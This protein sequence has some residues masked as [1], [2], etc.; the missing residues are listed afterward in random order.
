M[1]APAAL[2]LDAHLK[3]SLAAI[4]S[5]G[6][7]GIPVHV[8]SHRSNAMGFYSRCVASAFV[9]PSPLSEVAGFIQAIRQQATRI[10]T[11][12]LLAFSDATIL[13]LVQDGTII[14]DDLRYVLPPGGDSFRIASDKGLTLNLSQ[15]IGLSAPVTYS[16]EN[17]RDLSLI[18]R[19]LIYPVVLKPRHSV[20]W[21]EG[22]GVAGRVMLALSPEDMQRKVAFLAS[23]NGEFPLI[24]EFILG[25]EVG[26]EFLCDAGRVIACCAHRRLRSLSPRGGAAVLSETVPLTY[27]G[28]G[29]RAIQLIKALRW[30]GPIMVEFKVSQ[31][32]G[33]P[34][35]MEVNGRFWGSLPLA[36]T[37][38]VD[39]PYLYYKLACGEH[40]NHMYQHQN[41]IA[42]R[43]F[44]GDLKNLIE[45]LF[46]RDG[47]RPLL[48][49][50][51]LQALSNFV[52]L[53]NPCK[54]D[55][56][57]SR[58]IKPA[59]AELLDTFTLALQ[60]LIRPQIHSS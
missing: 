60:R 41:G 22:C 11:A 1:S 57:D 39:F 13:P 27:H 30:S 33:V 2:V 12:V 37:A 31:S 46:K 38:G 49:P 35:L 59:I 50:S 9:Y 48:Y 28:I 29:Q 43:H 55:V 14:G 15:E 19:E 52:R 58:D 26:A 23:R 42:S 5:L 20:Y 17:V 47:L 6:A 4:R 40:L 18:S 8:G 10:G 7:K 36:L 54:S 56:I 25:E 21:R 53:P 32:S 24:Q 16:C 34:K 44:L 51:R 45:V 3:S